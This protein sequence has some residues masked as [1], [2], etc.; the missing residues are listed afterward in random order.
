MGVEGL[1]RQ[2]RQETRSMTNEACVFF[3]RNLINWPR[4]PFTFTG[5]I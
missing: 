4:T 1:Q 5:Y 2:G 3:C